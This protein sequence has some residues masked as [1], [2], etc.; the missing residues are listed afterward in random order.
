MAEPTDCSLVV[1]MR[2][3]T[4]SPAATRWYAK[5]TI[6]FLSLVISTRFGRG[7]GQDLGVERAFGQC[8]LNTYQVD[9]R[10]PAVQTVE[11]V[12]MDVGVTGQ[13]EHG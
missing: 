9:L 1:A 8:I 12:A 13:S 3:G 2:P 5:P 10:Q 11:D 7:P 6:V 4:G